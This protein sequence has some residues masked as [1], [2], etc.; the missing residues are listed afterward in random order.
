MWRILDIIKS[1]FGFSYYTQLEN[2]TKI[3]HVNNSDIILYNNKPSSLPRIQKVSNKIIQNT[4]TGLT[5]NI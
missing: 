4:D 1:F 3:C 5:Y 2:D